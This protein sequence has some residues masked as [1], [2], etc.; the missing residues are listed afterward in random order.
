MNEGWFPDSELS[1]WT[2]RCLPGVTTGGV[3]RVFVP[4]PLRGSASIKPASQLSTSNSVALASKTG[5]KRSRSQR[6]RAWECDMGGGGQIGPPAPRRKVLP[7]GGVSL[8]GIRRTCRLDVTPGAIGETCEMGRRRL[9]DGERGEGP[10]VQHLRR[11]NIMPRRRVL[12]DDF[13]QFSIMS[14]MSDNARLSDIIIERQDV[15]ITPY[16]MT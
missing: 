8:A 14:K 11:G 1:L 4:L 7:V 15:R 13:G 12:L 3:R 6:P 9:L 16:S 2:D 10:V 5:P